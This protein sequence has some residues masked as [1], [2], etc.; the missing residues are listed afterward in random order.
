MRRRVAV[1]AM[2]TAALALAGCG[3]ATLD[4]GL[5]VYP[6]GGAEVSVTLLVPGFVWAAVKSDPSFSLAELEEELGRQHPD[7]KPQ[8]EE[9]TEGAQGGIRIRARFDSVKAAI[10]FLTEAAPVPTDQGEARVR[11]FVKALRLNQEGG[12]WSRRFVFGAQTDHTALAAVRALSGDPEVSAD[13]LA[14]AAAS[15]VNLRFSLTL[16]HPIAT[17]E[18]GEGNPAFSQDRR[19]VTWTLA[20]NRSQ[21][22]R[23]ESEPISGIRP[24]VL[25]AAGAF[26]L[27]GG[28][29][30]AVI[31]ARRRA[32]W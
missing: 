19:T 3:A 14:L 32:A 17:A 22:L 21:E 30:A 26:V 27:A 15:L 16:P 25:V 23:A 2:L 1:A 4:Q 20:F 5:V 13:D 9:I 18:G 8:V 6:D 29:A 28:A 10:R 7:L 24:A 11:P 12:M 31:G